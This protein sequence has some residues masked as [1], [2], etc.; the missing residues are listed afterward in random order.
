MEKAGFFKLYLRLYRPL[1]T[2]LNDLLSVQ[3]LS[4]GL[5]QV[6]VYLHDHGP[7]TLVDISGYYKVEKPSITRRIQRLEE[8]GLVACSPGKDRREK[9]AELTSTG[10]AVYRTCRRQ[11]TELEGL[12]LEGISEEEQQAVFQALLK[13]RNTFSQKTGNNHE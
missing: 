4:Y 3:G 8:L 6:V 1:I 2:A 9:V 12:A 5:W 10:M 7:S 13:I 11:I